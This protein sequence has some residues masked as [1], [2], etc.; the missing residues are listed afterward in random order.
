MERVMRAIRRILVAIK[1]TEA[2]SLPI[3]AKAAQLARALGAEMELFHAIDA[4]LY[5]DVANS[6]RRAVKQL[7]DYW[8]R[9]FAQQL[10]R[11]AARVRGADLKIATAVEWDYPGYEAI[12]RRAHRIAADL[13]IAECHGRRHVAPWLLHMTDWELLRLSPVPVLIV[14]SPRPYRHPVVLAAVDPSHA[15][16]KPGRLDEEIL[17]LGGALEEALRGTLHA[18]HAC[19]LP[20]PVGTPPIAW[21]RG[22]MQAPAIQAEIEAKAVAQAR[23]GFDRVLKSADIPRSRRHLVARHPIDA[24]PELA[25]RTHCAIV[26]MGAVSRSGLKS[27]FIGNTA[28]RVLDCLQC[29]LLVVKPQRFETRVPRAVRGVR[30]AAAAPLP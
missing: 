22:K 18:L 17:Q 11:A 29:D 3:V 21:T 5:T 4:P 16:A 25:R 19:A 27:I 20:L 13:I 12:I 23:P 10:D 6:D 1:Q 2:R 30:I 26:V 9:Q 14:K 24:I 8:C 28:E 7:A 15:F